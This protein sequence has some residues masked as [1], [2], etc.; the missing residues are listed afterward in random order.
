[1]GLA[2]ISNTGNF[3]GTFTVPD[4][5]CGTYAVEV[6][7]SILTES[8]SAEFEIVP[9]INM[10]SSVVCVGEQ[11]TITGSGF[12]AGKHTNISRF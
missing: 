10:S 3:T 5:Q 11:I 1:M 12:S 8:L 7:A 9:Q 6:V 2:Y 4:L